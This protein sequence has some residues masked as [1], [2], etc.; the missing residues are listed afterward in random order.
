[1]DFDYDTA[2]SRN[3]GFLTHK[4]T[5]ILKSKTVAIAGMGGVGG[6]YC[7]TLARLGICNFKIADFDC[8]EL[9][10]FNRQHASSMKTIDM[11]KVDVIESEILSINPNANIQKYTKGVT[12]ENLDEFLENVDIYLDGLDI[13]ALDIREKLFLQLEKKNIPGITVAPLGMG[14]VSM[15]FTKGSMPFESYFGL[16]KESSFPAKMLRFLTLMSP[17]NLQ[18]KYLVEK[19]GIKVSE[20]K[21]PSMPMGVVLCSGVA[22]TNCLKILLDRGRVYAAPWTLHFDAYLNLYKKKYN[23]LGQ[24][25]PIM[26]FKI[27]LVKKAMLGKLNDS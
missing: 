26:I 12:E 24:Y 17:K 20:K 11:A 27:W 18:F 7:I 2:F 10:N 19:A 15:V 4:E 8:F 16:S 3:I 25:N 5:E 6:Q 21:V 1:M 9:H 23:F 14:A 22:C 13:F